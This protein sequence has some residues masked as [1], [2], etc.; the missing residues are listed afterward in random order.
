MPWSTLNTKQFDPWQRRYQYRVNN[1]FTAAFT[2]STTGIGSGII[3]VCT[4]NVCTNT[5]AN[6]APF[7]IFSTGENGA[8][9]PPANLD[10]QENIDLDVDFVSH[11]FSNT[12]GGFDDIIVWASTNVLMNRMVTAGRLP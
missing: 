12:G 6:N 1:G 4:T 3:R 9:L 7:V 10:E 11:E 8:V 5:E 2:L